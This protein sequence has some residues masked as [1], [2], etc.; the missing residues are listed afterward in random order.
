MTAPVAGALA[1][2]RVAV[3]RAAR[4]SVELLE[5]LRARGAEALACP[6]IAVEPPESLAPLDDA[7]RTLERY[8]WVT[9]TSANAVAAVADRLAAVGAGLPAGLRLAAVGPATAQLLAA[10]LRAPDLVPRAALAEALAAEIADV[11]GRRVLF[12]RGDLASETL[13][14]TLRARG[15]TVDEVIAYRTVP[16]EGAGELARLVRE[17]AVDAILFMSASSVR[18]LL[19]ALGPQQ[20]APSGLGPH[21]PEV[22]CI[23]PETARA[24]RAAGLDVSAVAGDR[25]AASI[26]DAL[27]RSFGRN[28]HVEGR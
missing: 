8:D 13:A 12:P 3:T 2:R 6:T 7:L 19:D 17:G 4:Q 18:Y 26:V 11:A 16:G 10:R 9:F 28:G 23:G 15:A 20:S 21:A 25:T 5:L 24:A 22:V 1:G 27:E 14:R